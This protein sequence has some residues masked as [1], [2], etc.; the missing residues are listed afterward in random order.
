MTERSA[1]AAAEDRPRSLHEAAWPTMFESLQAAYAELTE[2]QWELERRAAEIEEAKE[3]FEQVLE[4]MSEGL[5]L[6]DLHGC[7]V[8]VNREA[9]EL[10]DRGEG[11]I[12]GR[13]LSELLDEAEVPATPWELLERAPEGSISNLD[14]EVVQPAGRR[15]PVS[16]SA[17]VIRDRRGKITGT[18]AVSRDI[19]ERKRAEE[20]LAERARELARSN[21]DLEQF[22]YVASH[23]LQEPLRMI[24][25]FSH[26]LAAR[27]R[28][29][30]DAEADEF[31]AYIVD[32]ATRMRRLIDDLLAY[33][34]VGRDET[35]EPTDCATV[36]ETACANLR[37]SIEEAGAEVSVGPLPTVRGDPTRLVQLFQNLIGNAVKFRAERP[38]KIE[39]GARRENGWWTFWVRDNGIGFEPEHA[40]RLFAIFSRRHGQRYPG[41]GMGLA[42]CKKIV[43]GHGGRIWADSEQDVG[44]TFLFTLRVAEAEGP[45]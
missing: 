33:S 21:A 7:V 31:I 41:T 14:I 35:F 30:L 18:L 22:A 6:M 20:A 4:S 28:H 43:E 44:S 25:G 17:A 3:L 27:Y 37:T 10:L 2:A 34:R 23:D 40:E 36:V 8:R 45:G 9:A 39:V 42:I 1:V 24:A 13:R 12:L 15:I 11:D 5:F 26:L 29:A 32:G 19:T 38:P 16:L